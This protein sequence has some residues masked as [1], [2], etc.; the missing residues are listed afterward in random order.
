MSGGPWLFRDCVVV[1]EEHDG[2]TNVHEYKLD[3]IPVWARIYGVPDGLTKKKEL[4]EK[5]ARKVGKDP[6]KVV[7]N[8]GHITSTKYL[9]VRVH[10]DLNTPLVGFVPITLK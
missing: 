1:I 6:V 10:I 5:I 7:V 3:R 9:R 2:F 8:D 4:A